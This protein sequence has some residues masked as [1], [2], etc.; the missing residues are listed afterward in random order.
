M[1]PMNNNQANFVQEQRYIE[2]ER[3]LKSHIG[4]ALLALLIF[5]PVGIVAMIL[6]IWSLCGQQ[7]RDLSRKFGN[8]VYWI[9]LLSICLSFLLLFTLFTYFTYQ[10]LINRSIITRQ[11]LT[12]YRTYRPLIKDTDYI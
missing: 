4:L 3:P 8:A 5:P 12:T 6:S 11:S 1:L 10:Y 7:D 2:Q 9:S